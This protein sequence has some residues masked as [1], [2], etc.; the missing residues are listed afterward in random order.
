VPC[1]ATRNLAHGVPQRR[2]PRP[3]AGVHPPYRAHRS[4]G[5]DTAGPLPDPRHHPEGERQMITSRTGE[6]APGAA[7]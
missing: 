7:R 1:A 6:S 3:V 2:E 4:R 5:A